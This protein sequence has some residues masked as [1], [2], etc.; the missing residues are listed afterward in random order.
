MYRVRKAFLV[1]V[2]ASTVL[3]LSA[4]GS[5]DTAGPSSGPDQTFRASPSATTSSAP[6]AAPTQTPEPEATGPHNLA[7]VDFA[8]AMIPHHA[9][10]IEMARIVLKRTDNPEI[11]A[12]ATRIEA[13][14]SPEI[15]L[16]SGWLT[17]W[18]APVPDTSGHD[19]MEMTGMMSESDLKKLETTRR[20]KVDALF[21]TQM[22]EHHRGAIAMAKDELTSGSNPQ[23][24]ELAQSIKK[25]QTAEVAE[26]KKLLA[27]V[28]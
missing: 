19:G 10:A 11:K 7:D 12:L 9:Q 4:C 5:S 8:A 14:Q 15:T 27:A 2:V 26:M 20:S 13:A 22:T 25:A 16:L 6:S 24:K 3:G 1:P 21:V 18:G 28:S 17:G 23:A